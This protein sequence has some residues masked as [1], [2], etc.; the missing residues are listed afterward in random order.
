M[1]SNLG[2]SQYK[3][4]MG[5]LSQ[6]WKNSICF[7]SSEMDI[8]ILNMRRGRG[9]HS[10]VDNENLRMLLEESSQ[11]SV[12]EMA[13]ELGVSVFTISS[14]LM[15]IEKVKKLNKWVPRELNEEQR[16]WRFALSER[17]LICNKNNPFFD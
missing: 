16:N 15:E 1:N 4:N 13:Q 6:F 14:H 17:L 5:R 2:N 3:A 9:H 7:Q 8:L 10:D 11:L 12:W